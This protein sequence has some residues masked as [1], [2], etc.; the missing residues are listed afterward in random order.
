[1]AEELGKIRAALLRDVELSV[2]M[3]AVERLVAV[4]EHLSGRWLTAEAEWAERNETS[5]DVPVTGAVEQVQRLAGISGDA[6]AK[7]RAAQEQALEV[8]KQ[9]LG[10]ALILSLRSLYALTLPG[11]CPNRREAEAA[12]PA[13]RAS[14]GFPRLFDEV[15]RLAAEYK[16]TQRGK[17]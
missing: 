8:T 10:Q 7:E 16:K 3:G 11:S 13:L 15:L 5:G 4:T 17:N 1:M 9:G 12:Y 14:V 6:R 2:E